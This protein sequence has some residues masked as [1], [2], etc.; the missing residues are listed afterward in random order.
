MTERGKLK[1]GDA[2]NENEISS[3]FGSRADKEEVRE[4]RGTNKWGTELG[5]E[6][7]AEKLGMCFW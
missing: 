3:Q 1:E 7:A 6:R 5:A 2:R 4:Q